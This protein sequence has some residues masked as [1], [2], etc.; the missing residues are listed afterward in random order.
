ME[1]V[2]RLKDYILELEGKRD[3]AKSYYLRELYGDLVYLCQTV[4]AELERERERL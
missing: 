1:D 4:I 3:T 2:E